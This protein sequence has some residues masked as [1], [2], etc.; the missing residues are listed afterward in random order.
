PSNLHMSTSTMHADRETWN[1]RFADG[2]HSPSK[3]DEFFVQAHQEYVAPLLEA[4][5]ARLVGHPEAPAI[6]GSLTALDVAAGTGRHGLWLA[7]RGWRVTMVDI[8][9]QGLALAQRHA[10]GRNV[11]VE[12]L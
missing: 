8:A 6:G 7:E 5:A 12:F 10:R 3:P 9:D 4:R 2:S 11:E 1:R